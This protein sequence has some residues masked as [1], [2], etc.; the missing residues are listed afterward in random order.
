M[1]M[2]SSSTGS[3]RRK[4]EA[5]P[6]WHFWVDGY[7]LLDS[8]DAPMVV[9]VKVKGEITDY[10]TSGTGFKVAEKQ[11]RKAILSVITRHCREHIS[12][13][14]FNKVDP[15]HDYAKDDV[16]GESRGRHL[17][18]GTRSMLRSLGRT[19]I[20]YDL[21]SLRPAPI[22]WSGN[23]RQ[24]VGGFWVYRSLSID[25]G[26]LT[27]KTIEADGSLNA[28]WKCH[29]CLEMN[30]GLIFACKKCGAKRPKAKKDLKRQ[31]ESATIGDISTYM[32][33]AKNLCAVQEVDSSNGRD[34]VIVVTLNKL[35]NGTVMN[36]GAQH[37][38]PNLIK[39][40]KGV[41]KNKHVNRSSP[42]SSDDDDD[43]DEEEDDDREEIEGTD[44]DDFDKVSN[45][46]GVTF[47]LLFSCEDE[48]TQHELTATFRNSSSSVLPTLWRAAQRL[49]LVTLRLLVE[50]FGVDANRE[51]SYGNTAIL[52]A[53]C[54]IYGLMFLK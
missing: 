46:R 39:K 17:M 50:N 25:S 43:D 24:F 34:N 7:E 36:S 52:L 44:N 19:V 5:Y 35:P 45:A 49:D 53:V 14:K 4:R 1:S 20:D 33:G 37:R 18:K 51:N 48:E 47:T 2:E 29:Y 41:K 9:T 15:N 13:L 22:Q 3:F 42:F 16:D 10:V 38:G 30:Q 26:Q 54:Y 21:V 12:C 40:R 32:L 31:S 8:N 6:L 11:T 23:I 27:L 28:H